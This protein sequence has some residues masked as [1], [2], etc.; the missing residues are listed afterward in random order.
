[1]IRL[2]S[3]EIALDGKTRLR[4]VPGKAWRHGGVE[5]DRAE[6]AVALSK[7][8]AAGSIL[9]MLPIRLGLRKITDHFRG[10]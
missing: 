2:F 5:A 7:A 6:Y 9:P 1:M 4:L 3:I 10:P 8:A